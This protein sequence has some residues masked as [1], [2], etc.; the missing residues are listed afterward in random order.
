M[1]GALY[2]DCSIVRL[3]LRISKSHSGIQDQDQG[4]D[5]VPEQFK[6]GLGNEPLGRAVWEALED[7]AKIW[8]Q[9]KTKKTPAH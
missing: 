3:D 7:G 6:L 1:P 9:R 8:E 2:A 4:Q 5:D